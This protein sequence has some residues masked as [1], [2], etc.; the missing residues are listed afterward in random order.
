M[1][2]KKKNKKIQKQVQVYSCNMKKQ[3]LKNSGL[4]VKLFRL[5]IFETNYR[6]SPNTP[7]G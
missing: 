3:E 7:C 5:V 2:P 1:D 6:N 4:E